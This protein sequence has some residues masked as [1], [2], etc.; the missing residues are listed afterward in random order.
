L[1][2]SVII[3]IA[4]VLMMA[5]FIGIIFS[6]ILGKVPVFRRFSEFVKEKLNRNEKRKSAP[7]EMSAEMKDY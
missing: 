5:V 3:V 6:E 1:A 4:N 2:L 7:P